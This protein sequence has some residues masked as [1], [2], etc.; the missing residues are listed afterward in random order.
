[1]ACDNHVEFRL[2]PVGGG[3]RVSW[4]MSGPMTFMGKVMNQVIDCEKMCGTQFDKGLG[5]LKG[6]VE[7][8]HATA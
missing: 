6:L 3:T 4:A 1:M 8:E 7:R 2:E 5:K